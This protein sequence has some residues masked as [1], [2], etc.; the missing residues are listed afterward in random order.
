MYAAQF[1]RALRK[2]LPN[3]D[4]L[5]QAG[6]FAPIKQWL[7][8]KIYQYGMLKTPGELITGITGEELNPDYLVH[9]LTKKYSDIYKLV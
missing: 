6:D 5:V 4:E 7:T 2:D 1:E 3:L 9:Y 8:D